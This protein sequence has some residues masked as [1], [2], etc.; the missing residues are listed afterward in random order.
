LANSLVHAK[1]EEE[2]LDFIFEAGEFS[3]NSSV[4]FLPKLVLLDMNMSGLSGIEVLQ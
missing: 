1:N 4:S 3:A 2:A